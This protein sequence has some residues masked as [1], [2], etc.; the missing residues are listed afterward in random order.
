MNA[1]ERLVQSRKLEQMYGPERIARM[2]ADR[3]ATDPSI[4]RKKQIYKEQAV[5][6]AN[7]LGAIPLTPIQRERLQWQLDV[8]TYRAEHGPVI[9]SG[10]YDFNLLP[11]TLAARN[12]L[13]G[14]RGME[15]IS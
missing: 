4:T 11:E 7:K 5:D 10:Y 15:G 13:T 2:V 14:G 3:E 6:I 8:L 1:Y 12:P 9:H